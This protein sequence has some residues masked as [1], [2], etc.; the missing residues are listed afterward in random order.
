MP[1][2]RYPA[3]SDIV[4]NSKSGPLHKKAVSNYIIK[5]RKQQLRIISKFY[6]NY[7]KNL[8]GSLNYSEIIPIPAKL[9]YSFNSVEIISNEFSNVF[10][11]P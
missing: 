4:F 6:A 9:E 5:S 7:L 3:F 10:E 2:L 8:I 1:N 11:I